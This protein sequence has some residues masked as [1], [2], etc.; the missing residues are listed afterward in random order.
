MGKEREMRADRWGRERKRVGIAIPTRKSSQPGKS[1]LV[2]RN[3]LNGRGN[4]SFIS[5]A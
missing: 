2:L 5:F 4:L 1:L 3:E